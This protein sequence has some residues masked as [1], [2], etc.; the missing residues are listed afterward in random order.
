M[1]RMCPAQCA[2][3]I[4]P[5]EAI[6]PCEVCG[7]ESVVSSMWSVW[8][9]SGARAMAAAL[10]ALRSRLAQPWP[11]P[12]PARL[13][14][15]G[16]RWRR[17][18]GWP[19]ALGLALLALAPVAHYSAIRPAQEKLE[20]VRARAM[21]QRERIEHAAAGLLRGPLSPAEQ[22]EEF[23]KIFPAEENSPQ[24]LERIFAEAQSQ[25]LSLDQGEY[26]VSRDKTGRL[27]RFQITLPVRGE[28]PQIRRF[29]AGLR[30]EVP[31]IAIEQVQFE[32]QK[33][34]DPAVEAKLRLVLY[35]GLGT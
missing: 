34:G 21:A 33:V 23:Y 15:A 5:Y 16:R 10:D 1:R 4:A 31:F 32:R 2:S 8:M 30:A 28:Y 25:G 6:T 17:A 22:L 12:S 18:W 7:E 29:L 13:R 3:L 26:R 35:L 11:M 20:A 19:G 24:W 14:W 27:M 9:G